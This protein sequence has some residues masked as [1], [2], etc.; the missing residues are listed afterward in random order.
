MK[1]ECQRIF[2]RRKSL[3]IKG[4]VLGT[5]ED[6]SESKKPLHISEIIS[7]LK[8]KRFPFKA[9]NPRNGLTVLLYTDKTF[10]K[11]KPGYFTVKK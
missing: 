10:Q 6:R 11:V 2:C 7:A 5:V 9:K 3:I 1:K 4:R 8:A